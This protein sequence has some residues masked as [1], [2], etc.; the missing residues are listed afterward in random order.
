[1]SAPG[2]GDVERH[3]G[4][5]EA[6]FSTIFSRYNWFNFHLAARKGIESSPQSEDKKVIESVIIC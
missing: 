4:L 5:G 2:I 3:Q 1:M 6:C